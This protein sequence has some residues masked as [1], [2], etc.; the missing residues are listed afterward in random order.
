MLNRIS[1][2]APEWLRDL[3]EYIEI[4]KMYELIDDADEQI[5]HNIDQFFVDGADEEGVYRWEE[6]FD[7]PHTGTMEDRKEALLLLL[8]AKIPYT[9]RWLKNY[10]KIVWDDPKPHVVVHFNGDYII[11]FQP[12]Q[13]INEAQFY[14]VMRK[15]IPAN[16]E[17]E[18]LPAP[19]V[20]DDSWLGEGVLD[21]AGLHL[22]SSGIYEPDMVTKAFIG[23][24]ILE[25][26]GRNVISK[27]DKELINSFPVEKPK[28]LF[29]IFDMYLECEHCDL[30]ETSEEGYSTIPACEECGIPETIINADVTGRTNASGTVDGNNSYSK[31]KFVFDDD[32]L[33]NEFYFNSAYRE[34]TEDETYLNCEHDYKWC[35]INKHTTKKVNKM[36]LICPKCLTKFDDYMI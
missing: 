4:W 11:T 13:E 10:L 21:S 29:E 12:K 9:F 14:E 30:A 18:I 2:H 26:E 36:Y 23:Q 33:E 34:G 32:V 20:I 3:Q 17:I 31:I 6:A 7:L 19:F 16:L 35:Y 25:S 1:R 8:Q 28:T 22:L 27:E 5:S 15:K 24:G